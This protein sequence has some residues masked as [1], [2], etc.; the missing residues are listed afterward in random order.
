MDAC[1]SRRAA[2]THFCL[3]AKG[4]LYDRIQRISLRI[5]ARLI[6]HRA[7]VKPNACYMS[8]ILVCLLNEATYTDHC[9]TRLSHGHSVGVRILDVDITLTQRSMRIQ[10]Y[11]GRRN[12]R[13]RPS[14]HS[15]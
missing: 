12:A 15:R 4:N 13:F 5:R 8:N 3:I 10:R 14:V 7:F 9:R 1:G 2:L 6:T 11:S